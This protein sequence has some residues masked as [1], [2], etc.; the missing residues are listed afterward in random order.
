[1][2]SIKNLPNTPGVLYIP[3]SE[4]ETCLLDGATK[5]DIGRAYPGA[6]CGVYFLEQFESYLKFFGLTLKE[7]CIRHLGIEW[8][9]CPESGD[10]VGFK[11][12]GRG[13]IFSRF[14]LGKGISKAVNPKFRK[15]CARM[16]RERSGAGNP[17]FGRPAW[18][19]GLT[20]ATNATVKMTAEKLI[21]RT[22][23]EPTRAKMRLARANSPIK[24]RHTT[25]HSPEMKDKMRIEVASRYGRGMYD[26]KSRIHQKVEDLLSGLKV[27]F[28]SEYPLGFYSIDIAL[29]EE[30]IAIE[31][32]GD[33]FH[34]NPQKY[35][36]GPQG[37]I[38]KKNARRDA[39]KNS[40]LKNNGWT[41]I[42][43]WESEINNPGFENKLLCDCKKLNLLK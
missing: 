38:Q 29:P 4:F 16:S 3:I 30:K 43:Y 9:R 15:S 20:A 21:G 11:R 24:A 35:P 10:E 22:P 5:K 13:L 31:I 2:S 26:R 28:Q 33:Y 34:S 32:D 8:P 23:D 12:D 40:Y 25:P 37:R 42:R 1:M 17:M 19:A 27:S 7:Y 36:D 39:A 18:N 41:I 6:R 14:K